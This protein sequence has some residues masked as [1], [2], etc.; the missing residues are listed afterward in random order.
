MSITKLSW[1]LTVILVFAASLSVFGA[2]AVDAESAASAVEKAEADIALAYRAVLEAERLGADVSGL[3]AQLNLAGEHLARA[4]VTFRVGDSEAAMSSAD[5]CSEISE[6]VR[7]E[8]DELWLEARR[9]REMEAW[10][11][12]S[13]SILGVFV[14]GCGGFLAWRRFKRRFHSRILEMRPEVASTES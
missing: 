1:A 6:A 10:L 3:L 12:L 9:E 7:I 8:A 13:G 14:V 11:K 2:L 4:E 5:V